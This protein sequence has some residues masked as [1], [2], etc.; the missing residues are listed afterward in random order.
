MNTYSIYKQ[1][2]I[3]SKQTA[4]LYTHGLKKQNVYKTKEVYKLLSVVPASPTCDIQSLTAGCHIII[5][6]KKKKKVYKLLLVVPVILLGISW[7]SREQYALYAFW[8][9]LSMAI[10][11]SKCTRTLTFENLWS[12]REQYA[13]YAFWN[14]LWIV[15]LHSKCRR[16]LTFEN[17]SR[18]AKQTN[19]KR[20]HSIV[21]EHIL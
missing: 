19:S 7:S 1:Q 20:T 17:V 3:R 6:K 10:F 21:R 13:Q 12:W 4:K 18:Y 5:F 16:A 15:T 8:K 2:N 14:V 11:Y 9:V